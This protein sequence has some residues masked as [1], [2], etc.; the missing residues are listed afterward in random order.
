MYGT[1]QQPCD[2]NNFATCGTIFKINESGDDFGNVLA[3]S[4][5]G[6]FGDWQR[7]RAA[8]LLRFFGAQ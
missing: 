3:F 7:V 4:T 2:P 6:D 1:T 5:A 8:A